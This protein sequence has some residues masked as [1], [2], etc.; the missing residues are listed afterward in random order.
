[1]TQETNGEGIHPNQIEAVQ[2][3]AHSIERNGAKASCVIAFGSRAFGSAKPESDLDT[4]FL[5]D[6]MAGNPYSLS[7]ETLLQTK[8]RG[9]ATTE[10]S[11]PA[12]DIHLFLYN[13]LGFEERLINYPNMA[14][15][16]LF[17]GLANGVV[18]YGEEPSI[19][20]RPLREYIQA[21][22]KNP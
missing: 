10:K 16:K 20:G 17:T 8:H 4:F 13:Q 18:I 12:G 14:S 11:G 9:Q 5:I 19:E 1:M 21:R 2:A 7:D 22:I 15:S 6:F 3:L